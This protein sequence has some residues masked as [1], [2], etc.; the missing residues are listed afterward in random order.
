MKKNEVLGNGIYKN[1]MGYLVNDSGKR[2]NHKGQELIEV[3]AEAYMKALESKMYSAA[4]FIVGSFFL[5]FF[6]MALL[7]NGENVTNELRAIYG[8]LVLSCFGL[9]F[10]FRFLSIGW[11]NKLYKAP[12]FVVSLPR[13]AIDSMAKSDTVVSTVAIERHKLDKDGDG[14]VLINEVYTLTEDE[15]LHK[16]LANDGNF[17]VLNFKDYVKSIFS[18]VQ[19]GFSSN[20]YSSLRAYESDLLYLRHKSH[21]ES[22]I[23]SNFSNRISQIR[24][25]GVLLK[26]FIVDD[27]YETLVVALTANMK[28][29]DTDGMYMTSSGDFPYILKFVRKKGVQTNKKKILSTGN[30]CNCGASIDVDDDG[31]CK[32]C[33]TSVVS[34]EN[35]WVL[36]D[37]KNIKIQGI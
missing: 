27:D 4:A 25:K 11:K 30:C 24:V 22:M 13:E 33:K 28:V 1:E 26:D 36:T 31:V 9:G 20:D 7:S 12:T 10:F 29:E 23:E 2:V 6:I 37:M 18:V 15:V 5:I 19:K 17:S 16:I 3:D 34:G 35:D 21:I 8:L 32:Y 14:K